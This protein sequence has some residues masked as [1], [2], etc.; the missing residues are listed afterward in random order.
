MVNSMSILCL[1]NIQLTS[2]WDGKMAYSTYAHKSEL[3]LCKRVQEF[4]LSSKFAEVI[5][6]LELAR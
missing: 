2:D 5:A 3:K 1:F 4:F 6:I